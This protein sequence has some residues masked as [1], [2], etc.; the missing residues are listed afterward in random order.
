MAEDKLVLSTTS[1]EQ[2]GGLR[3]EALGSKQIRLLMI[4]PGTK[5]SDIQCTLSVS[6]FPPPP[7]S[8][9]YPALSYTWGDSAAVVSIEVNGK[10]KGITQ[11]LEAALRQFRSQTKAQPGGLM[12]YA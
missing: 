11:N 10:R 6:P 7:D 9:S 3:Y 2:N 12:L 8:S 5:D 1:A 4:H